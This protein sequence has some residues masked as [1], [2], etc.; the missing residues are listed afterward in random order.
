MRTKRPFYSRPSTWTTPSFPE[1]PKRERMQMIKIL[2]IEKN[3]RKRET[4]SLNFLEPASRFAKRPHKQYSR[5]KSYSYLQYP[6]FQK[7][8]SVI[9]FFVSFFC[10]FMKK[11]LLLRILFLLQGHILLLFLP[12]LLPQLPE[13]APGKR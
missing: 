9:Y 10:F 7:P 12:Q 6:T 3:N 5:N 13:Q 1:N 4:E 8:S 2:R 11:S